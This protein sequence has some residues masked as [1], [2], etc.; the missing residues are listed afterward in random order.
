M[1]AQITLARPYAKAIFNQAKLSDKV[2]QWSEWLNY[3][4]ILTSDPEMEMFIQSPKS[5]KDK[6][7]QVLTE[8][9]EKHVGDQAKNLIALLTMNKRLSIV[10]DIV[11]LFEQY[12]ANDEGSVNVQVTV[13]YGLED[14]ERNTIVTALQSALNKTIQLDA[15]VDASIIGGMIVRAGDQIIDGSVLGNLNRLE[16][17]L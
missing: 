15:T 10:P 14:H 6:V 11:A 5:S 17:I 2:E 8:I 12:R 13:P 4:D 7:S 3:L 9:A 1:S 16:K